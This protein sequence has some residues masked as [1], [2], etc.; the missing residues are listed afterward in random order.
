MVPPFGRY[1]QHETLAKD[2]KKLDDSPES[3]WGCELSE[4]Y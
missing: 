2:T 3:F 1:F 4:F